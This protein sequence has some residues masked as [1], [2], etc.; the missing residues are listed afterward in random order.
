MGI[1]S[2]AKSVRSCTLFLIAPG[3]CSL[4]LS[5]NNS[6]RLSTV[7]RQ[8]FIRGC[9]ERLQA[10]RGFLRSAY[11][12]FPRRDPRVSRPGSRPVLFIRDEIPKRQGG[13]STCFTS[14][15]LSRDIVP[16]H[17]GRTTADKGKPEHSETLPRPQPA[18]DQPCFEPLKDSMVYYITLIDCIM[19]YIILYC[20]ILHVISYVLYTISYHIM[21]Y[22]IISYCIIQ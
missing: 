14:E 17:V 4:F 7:F 5:Q 3:P 21:L 16:L 8:P 6:M 18:S 12:S 22:Y 10:A 9:N 13:S 20:I 19:H 15:E 11:G 2:L 1:L